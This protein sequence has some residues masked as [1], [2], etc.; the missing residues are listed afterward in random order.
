MTFEPNLRGRALTLHVC[1]A[2]ALVILPAGPIRHD[3]HN[4]RANQ[5]ATPE[6]KWLHWKNINT[7]NKFGNQEGFGS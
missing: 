6:E 2:P 4:D 3:R 1:K 5:Q 7:P